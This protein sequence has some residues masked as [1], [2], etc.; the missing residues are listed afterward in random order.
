MVATLSPRTTI[1][2]INETTTTISGGSA[3]PTQFRFQLDANRLESLIR[4]AIVTQPHTYSDWGGAVTA[5]VYIPRDRA[6]VWHHITHYSRWTEYF[7]DVTRSEVLGVVAA[8][9]TRKR[10]YQTAQKSFFL[11]NLEVEVFLDVIEQPETGDT[12]AFRLERGSLR[13]FAADLWLY[14]Y[15][16]GTILSY[17]VQA[18]PTIPVPSCFIQQAMQMDLPNN[19]RQMRQVMCRG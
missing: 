7:P 3:A 2:A 16:Q 11:L 12:I 8:G 14:P 18:T 19:L 4:G 1:T 9:V 5:W 15:Q 17:R 6:Q 10:L 13:D